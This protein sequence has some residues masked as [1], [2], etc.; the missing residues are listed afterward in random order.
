MKQLLISKFSILIIFLIVFLQI[1]FVTEPVFA[2]ACCGG[3]FATPSIISG[4]DKAQMTSSLSFSQ[5]QS[6]AYT[7]GLWRKREEK[8]NTETLRIDG[9]HIF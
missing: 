5:V 2:S 6:D 3:G 7:N 4:N 8:E 9:A 1:I